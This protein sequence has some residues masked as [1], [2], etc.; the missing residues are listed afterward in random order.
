ML[1]EAR[2]Q[3]GL[4]QEMAAYHLHMDRRKGGLLEVSRADLGDDGAA[5][6]EGERGRGGAGGGGRD[7]DLPEDRGGDGMGLGSCKVCNSDDITV[8]TFG[9]GTLIL[10]N[11][12]GL[13]V[14][15]E[16]L[17]EAEERWNNLEIVRVGADEGYSRGKA[18]L[19]AISFM[20][21]M[22]TGF[23]PLSATLGRIDRKKPPKVMGPGAGTNRQRR[24]K[25]GKTW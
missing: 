2:E 21:Q 13:P 7:A 22:V 5:V 20:S 24:A 8:S 10:C 25:E 19:A 12:C 11:G 6:F 3:A 18:L 1:R 9:Q 14:K 4:S 15:A 23:D 16:T 17:E